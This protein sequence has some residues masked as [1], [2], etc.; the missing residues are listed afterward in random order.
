MSRTVCFALAAA[1]W[2]AAG[3]GSSSTPPA[4]H[5]GHVAALSGSDKPAGDQAVRGIRLAV[6]EANA[7]KDAPFRAI[8]HHTDT[9]GKL[10]AFEAEAVR[11]VTINKAVAVYGGTTADE[12][13]RLERGRS[14]LVTPFGLRTSGM[15]EQVFSTGLA[16]GHQAALLAR[17]AAVHL[18]VRRLAIVVDERG[19][20]YLLVADQSG[21]AFTEAVVKKDGKSEAAP[22]SLRFGKDAKFEELAQRL[23]EHKPQAIVLA[24]A[25]TDLAHLV[26]HLKEPR[27]KLLFAGPAGSLAVL[28]AVPEADGLYLTTAYVSDADTPLNQAF[29]KKFREAYSEAPDVHAA[30]AYDGMR[31]L[32]EAQRRSKGIEPVRGELAKIKDFPGLT[33]ALSF[34]DDQR[35]RRP[36][37]LVRLEKR[38]GRSAQPITLKR[39]EPEP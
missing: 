3:C 9:R 2:S 4:V 14:P 27:A 10:E 5:F 33:S 28:Q 26:R 32:L 17:Y 29:V 30:L 36:A 23:E 38:A 1:C 20:E 18:E 11:L 21:R 34:G 8:V 12:V 31:L 13:L 15:G 37:F 7:D 39:F 25:P 35:L 19:E 6:E 24:M 22:L 16:P